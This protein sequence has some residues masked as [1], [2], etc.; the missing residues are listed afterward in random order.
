MRQHY[1]LG[2]YLREVFIYRSEIL[3]ERYDDYQIIAKAA[4]FPSPIIS[5]YAQ[6]MGIYTP[7]V[8]ESLSLLE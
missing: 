6:L 7:G 1:L 5:A 8:A 3:R 4:P 2:R